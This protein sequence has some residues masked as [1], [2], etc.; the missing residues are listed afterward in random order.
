MTTNLWIEQVSE[1][2]ICYKFCETIAVS[3]FSIY[4]YKIVPN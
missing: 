3:Y 2:K 4:L 1:K